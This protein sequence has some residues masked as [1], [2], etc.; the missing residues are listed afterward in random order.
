MV[1][2]L[3]PAPNPGLLAA[4]DTEGVHQ[5]RINNFYPTVIAESNLTPRAQPG[6]VVY[7]EFTDADYTR[8]AV[9]YTHLRAHEPLR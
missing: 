7:I 2:E 4:D 6:D 9:S 3:H 5:G 1:P 8:G